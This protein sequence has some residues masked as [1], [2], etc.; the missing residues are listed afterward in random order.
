MSRRVRRKLRGWLCSGGTVKVHT[1]NA[2]ITFAELAVLGKGKLHGNGVTTLFVGHISSV[3]RTPSKLATDRTICHLVVEDD[4]SVPRSGEMEAADGE[5]GLG[6]F[7][8]DSI[9][10]IAGKLCLDALALLLELTLYR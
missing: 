5:R 6:G 4:L 3:G 10:I 9:V 8:S 1:M 2:Q 7:H